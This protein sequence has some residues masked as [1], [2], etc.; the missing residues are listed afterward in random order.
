MEIDKTN[1]SSKISQSILDSTEYI[2]KALKVVKLVNISDLRFHE[3]KEATIDTS[4]AKYK[5]LNIE[6]Q[7]RNYAEIIG[8]STS[9][10]TIGS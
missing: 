3:S 10:K 5:G 9:S 1:I 4:F 6:S 2:H 8:S 7:L